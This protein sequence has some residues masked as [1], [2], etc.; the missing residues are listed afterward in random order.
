MQDYIE[1]TIHLIKISNLLEKCFISFVIFSFIINKLPLKSFVFFHYLLCRYSCIFYIVQKCC[2]FSET[3]IFS[4]TVKND[5]V[6]SIYKI[7]YFFICKIQVQRKVV[8]IFSFHKTCV[9]SYV[10]SSASL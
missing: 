6:C 1:K 4:K 10:D 3:L 8:F 2:L 7:I 9:V 5:N